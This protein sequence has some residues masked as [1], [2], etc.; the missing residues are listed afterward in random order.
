MFKKGDIVRVRRDSRLWGKIVA[1]IPPDPLGS[2]VTEY[3]VKG[4]LPPTWIC[5]LEEIEPAPLE[6][7]ADVGNG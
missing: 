1:I 6:A 2:N 7:L 3:W 5:E 4:P